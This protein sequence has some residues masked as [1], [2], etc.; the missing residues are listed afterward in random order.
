MLFRYRARNYPQ[1]LSPAEQETWD[2]DRMRRLITPADAQ[3]F[4]FDGFRA[5]ISS[6]RS[7]YAGDRRA[8]RILDQ[9]ES[10]VLETGLERLWR[11]QQ[12]NHG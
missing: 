11:Q 10:W 6:Y 2:M 12:P 8:Q 1:T 3:Q 9:L 4:S 5:V 7:T